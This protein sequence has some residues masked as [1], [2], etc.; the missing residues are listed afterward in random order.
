[1]SL[2][3]VKSLGTG[4]VLE[5]L[6]LECGGFT[7]LVASGMWKMAL[8]GC[9]LVSMAQSYQGKKHEFWEELGAIKDLWDDPWFFEVIEE[10]SLKDLPSFGGVFQCALPRIV[11]DHCPISL[12]DRED[13]KKSVNPLAFEKAEAR[14]RDLE[15]YKNCVLMEETLW[16]QKSR[17]LW[18]K[19]GT[20]RSRSLE[21]PFSEK[22]VFEALCSLSINKTFDESKLHFSH[23]NPKSRGTEEL[24]DFRLISLAGSLY[25]L[26]AKVLANRLKLVVV[27]VVSEY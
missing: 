21:E 16:R 12:E 6:E 9:S 15:K 26:L 23:S 1:M 11:S 18:L 17:K 7:I 22:E 13:S 8:F 4:R 25:K 5:L 20:E 14:M 19:E 3:V 2:K 24:K 10:L 27:E